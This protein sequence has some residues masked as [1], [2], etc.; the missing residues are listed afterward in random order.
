MN[1]GGS[2]SNPSVDVILLRDPQIAHRCIH[3]APS[4]FLNW[5]PQI[6]NS[7]L[8]W[9]ELWIPDSIGIARF[10]Q[11]F[12][13]DFF[14]TFLVSWLMLDI[15]SIYDIFMK[16]P[17]LALQNQIF[18]YYYLQYFF[19]SLRCVFNLMLTRCRHGWIELAEGHINLFLYASWAWWYIVTADS[20]KMV[21]NPAIVKITIT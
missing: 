20:P 1:N 6:N 17:L 4:N 11:I 12:W 19:E 5:W 13:T 3:L 21:K 2:F 18:D 8:E 16:H 10:T 15:T 7:K 9:N 14:V